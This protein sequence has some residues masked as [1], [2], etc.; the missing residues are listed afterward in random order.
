MTLGLVVGAFLLAAWVDDR[1][2]DARPE[3]P[4]RRLGHVLLGLALL[5]AS[6]GVLYLVNSTGIPQIAFMA[7][8]LAVF[9]PALTYSLL[10]ALWLLRT[11]VEITRFAGR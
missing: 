10:T 2:G 8:V 9:L 11:L 1:V 4:K 5:E 7:V 3:S 6:V